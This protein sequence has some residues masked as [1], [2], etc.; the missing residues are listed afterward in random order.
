VVIALATYYGTLMYRKGKELGQ[1]HP[2][3]LAYQDA[4]A[5]LKQVKD[6]LLNTTPVA[7]TNPVPVR[8]RPRIFNPSG[9]Q[10]ATMFHLSDVGLRKVSGFGTEGPTLDPEILFWQSDE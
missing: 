4:S 6:G 7:D 10:G 5:V 3:Y 9:Q 1:F 2:V 8:S